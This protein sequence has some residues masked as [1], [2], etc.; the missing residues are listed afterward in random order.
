MPSS[1]HNNRYI[2]IFVLFLRQKIC[3]PEISSQYSPTAKSTTTHFQQQ[4][5]VKHYTAV[6]VVEGTTKRTGGRTRA[7]RICSLIKKNDT[8]LGR[9]CLDNR[10]HIIISTRPFIIS[11]WGSLWAPCFEL[12]KNIVI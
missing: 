12:E 2:L 10:H 8:I 7:L 9:H 3:I 6:D 11:C 5:H 1:L 4:Q